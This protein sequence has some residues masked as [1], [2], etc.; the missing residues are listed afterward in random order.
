MLPQAPKFEVRWNT[1]LKISSKHPDATHFFN[2]G[3]FFAYGFNHAEAERAFKEAIRLDPNCAMAH[4]GLALVLG[5]NINRGMR[6]EVN[7][8]AMTHAQKALSLMETCTPQEKALI[9]ALQA[10]Y[11]QNPPKDRKVLDV[12][13]ADAMRKVV[14][15]FPNEVEIKTLLAEALMDTMPWDYWQKNGAPKPATTEVHGL[16]DEVLKVQA[17]HPGANHLYIHSVEANQP[18]LA[19]AA[20]DQLM[21]DRYPAGHLIHMPAH[22]YI[23]LGRYHDANTSNQRAIEEDETY[24]ETCQR[25]GYY[26]SRYYPHNVHFLYFGAAMTGQSQMAIDAARKTAEKGQDME[27]YQVVPLFALLRFG[28]WDDLLAEPKQKGEPGFYKTFGTTAKGWLI[29]TKE[30]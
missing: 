6:K 4:W 28:K 16:L 8:E 1:S 19:E 3:L 17:N 10:R 21:A 24:I 18:E 23:R 2:Q 20:A 11:Q 12:A 30:I 27:R 7:Q 13:Y 9:Q 15:D 22:I 29:C 26:P 5:P 14:N 25:D